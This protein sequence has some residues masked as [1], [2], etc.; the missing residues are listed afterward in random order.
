MNTAEDINT[1]NAENKQERKEITTEKNRI[2]RMTSPI[3]KQI[4][5][6]ALY[7]KQEVSNIPW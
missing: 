6:N 1:I 5:W 4:A 2:M 3:K 7:P